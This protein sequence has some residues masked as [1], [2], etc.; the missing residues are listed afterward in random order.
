MVLYLSYFYT[1][2]ECKFPSLCGWTCIWK[3]CPLTFI[4]IV[5]IRLAFFFV[6]SSISNIAGA[7]I[8]TG[9]LR[10]RGVGG[11]PGW[12]YLFLV[13]GCI[14]LLVG[15]FSFI[16][17]PPGPTQTKAWFRPKG[18][19]TERWVIDIPSSNIS[20]LHMDSEETIMVNRYGLFYFIIRLITRTFTY[21]PGFWEMILQSPTC[22]IEKVWMLGCYGKLCPIGISG[23]CMLLR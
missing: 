1:K 18:W 13:E 23:P 5:P 19:F 22:T 17:M 11:R 6:A 9:I 21:N 8:A 7:F 4:Q 16:F 15:L 12:R 2:T 3:F 20:L 10:L 14:T